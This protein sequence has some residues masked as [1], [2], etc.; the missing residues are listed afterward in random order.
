MRRAER[1]NLILLWLNEEKDEGLMKACYSNLTLY[2]A[3]RS[4]RT[5]FGDQSAERRKSD[6]S[7]TCLFFYSWHMDANVWRNSKLVPQH[8]V[9]LFTK[10]VQ[11]MNLCSYITSLFLEEE[12]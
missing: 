4:Q 2:K 6:G 5:G 12:Y 11:N 3:E 8:L 7:R 9:Y 10:M 1:I